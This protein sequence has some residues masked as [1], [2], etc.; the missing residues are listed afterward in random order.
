[1][2]T[3]GDLWGLVGAILIGRRRFLQRFGT[4]GSTIGTGFLLATCRRDRGAAGLQTSR[5]MTL[6]S[7]AFA[8]EGEIPAAFTCDGHDSSPDLSWDAPPSGT[9]SLTL[10]LEDGDAPNSPFIHWILY[11]LAAE[12][13]SLPAK[14]PAQPFLL[15]GGVQGK[16]GFGQYGYRGPCPPSGSHRYYFKLYAV[17]T[18]L[19]LP[20]GVTYPQVAA[21]LT[22]HLLA[23]AEL[24]GRYRRPN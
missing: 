18:V 20:P 23:G 1:M 9:R 4:I 21:A 10:I 5:T 7:S 22:G 24:M 17:D 13:R 11:D 16:N 8:A 12:T 3:C 6:T 2:G 15:K 14:I 19:D